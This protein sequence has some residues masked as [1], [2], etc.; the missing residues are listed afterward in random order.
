M[1]ARRASPPDSENGERAPYSSGGSPTRR[2]RIARR[3]SGLGLSQPHVARAEG[4]VRCDRLGE[5][6]GLGVLEDEPDL[7]AGRLCG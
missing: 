6:L 3:L 5:E 4:D 7:A 2:K 1:A